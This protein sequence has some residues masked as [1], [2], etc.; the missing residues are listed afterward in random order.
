MQLEM[1]FLLCLI[2]VGVFV[3]SLISFV[4]YK[5]KGSVISVTWSALVAAILCIVIVNAYKFQRPVEEVVY[6]V[7]NNDGID[8]INHNGNL[9][10]L[11]SKF[12]RDFDDTVKLKIYKASY[13]G[14][15][16]L[17]EKIELAEK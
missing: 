16:F 5:D 7:I 14:W 3:F 9:I 4:E 15:A 1:L 2:N 8:T 17:S 12:G 6:D 11:N 13:C 10:N